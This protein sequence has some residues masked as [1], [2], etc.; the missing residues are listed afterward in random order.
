MELLQRLTETPGIAGREERIREL[1]I[2][3]LTPLVDELH[4]DA[5]GNVIGLRKGADPGSH[6]TMLVAH[7]D[8]IGFM[9]THIDDEGFIRF[10]PVGGFDARTLVA[11]RVTVHGRK[12]LP[13]ILMPGLKPV[14]LMTD[15]ERKKPLTLTDFFVDTGLEHGQ[16][17]E[18]VDLGDPITLDRPL[19]CLGN[20]V[21]GKALDDRAGVYVM[22]EALRRVEGHSSD[23]YA[24]ASVQ[25]E[26]GL[27]GA[28]AAGYGVAPDVCLA[29]DVTIAG[30]IPG[31]GK[32]D[33]VTTLG[34]G[35][36]IKVMDSASISNPRL[37]QFLKSTAE[38]RNISYQLEI[39][40]RGG[41]DA[42]AVETA[43][44]GVP[45]GTISIPTRYV[46]TNLEAAHRADMQ[47]SIELLV[48]FLETVHLADLS[49]A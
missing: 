41:T 43:R 28:R 25:E 32:K 14:H 15:E 30:D 36:A 23:I 26:R 34:G 27:R 6:R 9:V 16:V 11:Q 38:D 45:V 20:L 24:V 29:L 48:G 31:G 22:L 44:D 5:M 37:V 17:R 35:T 12:D 42:A 4:V 10:V 13:G 7:M 49:L 18:L 19:T 39:L 2:Q 8:E 33:R 46:H 21:C 1:I 40:P 3:E 47:A